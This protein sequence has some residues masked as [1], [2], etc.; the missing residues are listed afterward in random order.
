MCQSEQV[1][2]TSILDTPATDYNK[3]Q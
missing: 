3:K 2:F 1:T